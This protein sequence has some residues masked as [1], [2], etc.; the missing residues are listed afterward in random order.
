[1]Y[2]Q[3]YF[4]RN[5]ICIRAYWNSFSQVNKDTT[6][7]QAITI[8]A[9]PTTATL[10][11]SA[12]S[13]AVINRT[14]LN[15]GDGVILTSVLNKIP[16]VYMQQGALNTNRISIRGIGSRAQYGTQK[17]K[18]YYEGIPLTTAEGSSTI[19]DIDMET[20][21]SIEIIKGPNSTSFGSGLGGVINLF[22]R[23][24]PMDEFQT[25]NHDLWKL[26]TFE[27]KFF[28]ELW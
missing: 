16:G 18:A 15:K 11:N 21:G 10:Q 25:S 13:I 1:V 8:M 26:R 27:T 24:I 12:A 28:W 22:A 17:I 2:K 7:L 6:A 3:F 14:D 4:L 20:I 5:P 19:E 9:S 23:E